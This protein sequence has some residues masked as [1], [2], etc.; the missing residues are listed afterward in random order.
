MGK[1]FTKDS[2]AESYDGEKSLRDS[3][4]KSE[5]GKKFTKDSDAEMSVER[6]KFIHGRVEE[7]TR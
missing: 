2:D 6:R 1:K 3:D 5:E 4:A 7:L